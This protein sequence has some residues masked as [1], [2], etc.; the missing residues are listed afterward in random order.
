[1]LKLIT[2]RELKLY[3]AQL[4]EYRKEIKRLQGEVEHERSRA[5]AA[6]NAVL[7]KT[8]KVAI[9]LDKPLTFEQQEKIQAKA[10][11]IFGDGEPLTDEE[12]LEKLQG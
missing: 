1:M 11:D 8:A 7:M 9:N 10:M 6:V 5:D 4:E 3:A 2:S 12:A